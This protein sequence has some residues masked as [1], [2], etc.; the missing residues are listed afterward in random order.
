VVECMVWASVLAVMASQATYRLVREQVPRRSAIPLL[1][2]GGNFA[3]AARDLLRALVRD[4]TDLA[5]EV[6]EHLRRNAPDP[7]INRSHRALEPVFLGL[8][9]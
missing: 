5:G 3:N 6:F 2:W 4:A 8:H 9:A 7:N 1:R